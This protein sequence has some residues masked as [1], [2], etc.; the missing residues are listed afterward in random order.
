MSVGYTS[1]QWSRHKVIYDLIVIAFVAIYVIAFVAVSKLLYTGTR[2]VS[3]E[4]TLIR[5]TGS[6]AIVL[7]HIILCIG[8]LARLEKRFLPLLYNRRHLGVITFLVALLHAIVVTGYYHGFGVLNPL[9][10]LLTSNTSFDSLAAFPF[11]LPGL[12][13]LIILFFMAATSHDFWLR[14]LSARVWKTLHMLVYIAYML[15][16]AHV[17]LGA[18]QSDQFMLL[19]GLMLA[20]ALIVSGVHIT[21]GLHER[22]IDR[23]LPAIDGQW[24]D[25]GPAHDIPHDR[26]RVV[27]TPRGERIA[28]FRSGDQVS[29]VTNVC[30][31]QGGPL[32]EGK[33]I[34]GCVTCPWHGWQYRA[35]DGCAPPPFVEKVATYQVRVIAGRVQVSTHALPPGTPTTPVSAGTA[36]ESRA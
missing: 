29:A 12:A 32:G 21:A 15:L 13:A 35:Q 25:V 19:G 23:G 7:L 9:I 18:M 2:A 22:R 8:P 26:A 30:A 20:G 36:Q 34:D 10:S 3:D 6:C 11:E 28:V 33:V 5:A 31:H 1:V 14:N 4:V 27:C 24:V 16:V 17:A